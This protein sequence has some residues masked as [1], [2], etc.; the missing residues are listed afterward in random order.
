MGKFFKKY[1]GI[2]IGA[3]GRISKEAIENID[4]D[5]LR[6][7]A[8]EFYVKDIMAE[9][10][11][12]KRAEMML[13]WSHGMYELVKRHGRKGTVEQL[14]S[15]TPNPLKENKGENIPKK[16]KPPISDIKR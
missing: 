16:E 6:L 8:T 10:D 4:A 14:I 13:E 15:D 12:V 9:K 11:P 7:A 3:G 2:N 5:T 1:L